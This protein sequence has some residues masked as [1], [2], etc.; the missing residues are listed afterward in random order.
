M[1]AVFFLTVDIFCLPFII[2]LYF[3]PW[4]AAPRVWPRV[5]S[6]PLDVRI[7]GTLSPRRLAW[8]EENYSLIEGFWTFYRVAVEGVTWEFH[9]SL[10]HS[11]LPG[12]HPR[13]TPYTP[14]YPFI[15]LLSP[16]T[17]GRS[18]VW[19]LRIS[20]SFV[21]PGWH[22]PTPPTPF[23]TLTI[24]LTPLYTRR[25]VKVLRQR[26]LNFVIVWEVRL[27]NGTTLLFGPFLKLPFFLLPYCLLI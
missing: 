20:L 16:G 6:P 8:E 21:L 5:K 18:H 3:S 13:Y 14:L 27:S 26:R 7:F 17:Y 23:Y 19:G 10:Y 22:S 4:S 25:R 12:V 24:S 2:L 11:L 9:A 15:L 1:A